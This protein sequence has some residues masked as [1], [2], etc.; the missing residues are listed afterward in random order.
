MCLIKD[1]EKILVQ[2]RTKK[3]WPGLTLPGGKVKD[4]ETI[5]ESVK[6]EIKEETGLDISDV[7]ERGYIEWNIEDR[8]HLC[9]LFE[10]SKF[11]GDLRSSSEGEVWSGSPASPY[12]TRQ[13][14]CADGSCRNEDSTC[15]NVSCS[16]SDR[17]SARIGA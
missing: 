15:R 12:D 3:D 2:E 13:C 5:F 8:R 6:R 4:D 1:A 14:H 9:I 10:S 17:K 11:K 16:S 7:K